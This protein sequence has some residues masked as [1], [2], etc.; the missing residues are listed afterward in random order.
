MTIAIGIIFLGLVIAG[1]V[2]I[3]KLSNREYECNYNP[4]KDEITREDQ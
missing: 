1:I 4:D 3:R 2:S